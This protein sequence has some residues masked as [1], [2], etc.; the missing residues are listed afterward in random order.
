VKET[1]PI[2]SVRAADAN[3]A[4]GKSSRR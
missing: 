2:P 3:P 4:F 1:P